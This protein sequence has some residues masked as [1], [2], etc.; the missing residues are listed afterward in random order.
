MKRS[1]RTIFAAVIIVTGAVL[2]FRWF[3]PEPRDSQ[4][5]KIVEQLRNCGTFEDS[6]PIFERME[7]AKTCSNF[8]AEEIRIRFLSEDEMH[9]IRASRKEAKDRYL[10]LRGSLAQLATH[11]SNIKIEWNNDN[12]LVMLHVRA[13]GREPNR[14]DYF[15]EQHD[16]TLSFV[17]K[18]NSDQWSLKIVQVLDQIETYD[19]TKH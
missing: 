9:E 10:A 17:K 12:P 14:D 8:L 18:S 19:T 3:I 13:M 5:L 2:L 7:I 6:K 16:V 4:I 15:L 11:T 1:K